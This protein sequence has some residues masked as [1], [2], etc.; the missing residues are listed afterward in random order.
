MFLRF[1]LGSES[2]NS[3][4]LATGVNVVEHLPLIVLKN[5][6]VIHLPWIWTK[7]ATID[8]KS[9]SR[10]PI[11]F[12]SHQFDGVLFVPDGSKQFSA[13]IKACKISKR[14]LDQIMSWKRP[15][16]V[17]TVTSMSRWHRW[18]RLEEPH[19][20]SKKYKPQETRKKIANHGIPWLWGW[21][22]V[23]SYARS[24]SPFRLDSAI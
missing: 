8:S 13:M 19:R 22:L 3:F 2:R 6:A 20:M 16:T 4:W 7:H 17:T 21:G 14:R 18:H 10:L 1:V 23:S 15:K 24:A 11:G 5:P 9:T 12:V